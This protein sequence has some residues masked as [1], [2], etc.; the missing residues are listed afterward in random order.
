MIN[1]GD[2]NQL[3]WQNANYGVIYDNLQARSKLRH[4]SAA[5]QVPIGLEEDFQGLIDLVHLKAYYFQ[6]SSGFVPIND[7]L[8]VT[9]KNVL[10][11]ILF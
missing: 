1:N 8:L 3:G 11:Q 10:K 7:S 5:V 4:H 6:G 9:S 2:N